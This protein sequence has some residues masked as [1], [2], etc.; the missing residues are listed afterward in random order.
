MNRNIRYILLGHKWHY[1]LS[2]VGYVPLHGW[3]LGTTC[4]R[5]GKEHPNPLP[6]PNAEI[7]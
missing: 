4:Q 3:P 6:P 2:E 1:L 7:E 5:C